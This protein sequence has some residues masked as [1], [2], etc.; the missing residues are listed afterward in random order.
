[1]TCE[2]HSGM[3][4]CSRGRWQQLP[5]VKETGKK[6]IVGIV[7]QVKTAPWMNGQLCKL[8]IAKKN[9]FAEQWIVSEMKDWVM[10]TMLAERDGEFVPGLDKET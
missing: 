7:L 3:I 1:M 6:D 4:V 8:R 5:V 2:W 9:P 10:G